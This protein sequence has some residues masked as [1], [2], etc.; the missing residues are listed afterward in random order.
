MSNRQAVSKNQAASILDIVDAPQQPQKQSRKPQITVKPK[1]VS[2]H[3]YQ[4]QIDKLEAIVKQRINV[5]GVSPHE[6]HRT[7]L[8]REAIDFWLEHGQGAATN[9]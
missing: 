8:I 1:K 6:I 5:S 3:L 9:T 4:D 2:L 7:H